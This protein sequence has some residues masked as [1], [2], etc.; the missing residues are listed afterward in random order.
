MARTIDEI[1]NGIKL[2][3]RTYPSLDGFLFPED[4]GS[5]TGVFNL[6]IYI[7]SLAI[8]TFETLAD[9]FRS[10]VIN[11]SQEAPVGNPQWVRKQML[12]F[13]LGDTIQLDE[14]FL[15][16]Y[17]PVDESARIVTNCSVTEE[18]SSEIKIKVAKTVS[19]VITPL[20]AG[21]IS[22]LEDYYYGAADQQ[23]VGF[24]GVRAEFL[25]IPPDE[26]AI[27]GVV[28]YFGQY[29]EANVK[30]EVIEVINNHLSNIGFDG[31]IYMNRLVA[32]VE[33]LEGVNNFQVSN[34]NARKHDVLIND[35]LSVPVNG[36]Y[37]TIAGYVISE[38]T[39]LDTLTNTISM[40]QV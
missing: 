33:E 26:I 4:G 15:P 14:N 25:S 19:D 39:P 5:K 1:Q 9:Q 23:G 13:Q 32:D 20:D 21:E 11:A 16:Y 22:A 24:A 36:T 18:F 7:V 35:G 17:D 31:V 10:D 27:T 12:L 37:E 40:T 6:I 30:A 2:E 8:F 28:S 29:I 38:T 34:V 3:V